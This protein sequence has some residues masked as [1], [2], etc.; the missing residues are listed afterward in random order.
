MIIRVEAMSAKLVAGYVSQCET[1]KKRQ[2]WRIILQY[3]AIVW[4]SRLSLLS[5]MGAR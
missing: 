4:I 2:N 1:A 5:V 3:F